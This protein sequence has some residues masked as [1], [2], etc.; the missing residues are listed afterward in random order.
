[1]E[2][3]QVDAPQTPEDRPN[4]DRCWPQPRSRDVGVLTDPSLYGEGLQIAHDQGLVNASLLQRELGPRLRGQ[5]LLKQQQSQR[6]A[7]QLIIESQ[8]FGWL[9]TDEGSGSLARATCRLTE[10]GVAALAQFHASTRQFR[11]LLVNRMQTVFV[12][13]GWMVDRLW[14]INPA[15]Q[16]E[17]ILPAPPSGWKPRSRPWEDAPWTGDLEAQTRLATDRARRASSSAFPVTDAGWITAVR[18]AW[19]HLSSRQ[20]R[21]RQDGAR[22]ARYSPRRR[23]AQAMRRATIRLL[24]DRVPPGEEAPDY[25]GPKAPFYLKSF[26][27]WCAR[28]LALELLF[29][30]YWHPA[31]EGRLLFPVSLFRPSEGGQFECL[32]DIQHPDGRPLCLHQ[33]EWPAWRER[34]WQALVDVHRPIS[35][36][37]RAR[38][39][40]LLDVRDEVCRQ[41][42]LS[43]LRFEEFLE[44]TLQEPPPATCPWHISAETDLREDLRSGAALLRRPVHVRRVP[45]TLIA[46]TPPSGAE[47]SRP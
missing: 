25:S 36:R 9:R 30:T 1:M 16:G 4:M 13:P 43:A 41:L 27:V 19:E 24:F 12:V 42:R 15:G 14:L 44:R 37:V 34:F 46:V 39:V 6:V 23:L 17:V 26:E 31:V 8:R 11:R 10:A 3:Q 47:R 2:Q 29:Y 45:H 20:P 32:P 38:Y 18:R 5:F 7:R 22:P 40:S 35:Q 21:G 33:P 28:L